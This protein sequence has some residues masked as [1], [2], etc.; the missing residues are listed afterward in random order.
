MNLSTPAYSSTGSAVG[1]GEGTGLAVGKVV[2]EVIGVVDAAFPHAQSDEIVKITVRNISSFLMEKHL[3]TI[4][5]DLPVKTNYIETLQLLP[6]LRDMADDGN[7]C[8]S[9]IVEMDLVPRVCTLGY[10]EYHITIL[11]K[12]L[13]GGFSRGP[14]YCCT[15]HGCD[16]W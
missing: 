5:V 15:R 6:I 10:Q 11:P 1:I 12:L 3:P 13:Q 14:Q 16:T 4:S 9:N 8:F 2:V 7:W